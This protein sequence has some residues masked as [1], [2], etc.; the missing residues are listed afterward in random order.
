MDT[1]QP[2]LGRFERAREN[3]GFFQR[4]L[5]TLQARSLGVFPIL[6]LMIAVVAIELSAGRL[7]GDRAYFLI[8]VAVTAG[9]LF[10]IWVAESCRGQAR[11]I[12]LRHIESHQLYFPDVEPIELVSFLLR[13]TGR[14]KVS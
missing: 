3:A 9:V 4:Q 11:R 12:R 6:P 13:P 2:D 1:Q 14:R 5:D 8:F 7:S 10:V